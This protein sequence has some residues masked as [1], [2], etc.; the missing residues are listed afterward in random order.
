MKLKDCFTVDA[1]KYNQVPSS[2]IK[3]FLLLY[4][5]QSYSMPVYLR[6][7]EYFF[8]K[9][10]KTNNKVYLMFAH[11]FKRKNETKNQF[12]HGFNHNIAFGTLF[13]H[14]NVTINDEISIGNNVQIFKNVTFALSNGKVCSIGDHSIIFS[15]VIILGKII[16]RNCVIGAGNVLIYKIPDNSV[17]TGNP[18]SIIKQCE[19]AHEY[20]EHI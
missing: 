8:A 15:H 13:H 1:H 9:Y 17:V 2:W 12:E 11:F 3:R 20:L 6:L 5:S 19:N 4:Y 18:A 14:T 16:G 7:T 10:K